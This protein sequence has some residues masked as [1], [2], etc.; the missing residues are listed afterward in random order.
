MLNFKKWLISELKTG[1][2][3]DINNWL[4]D[5]E[6][7]LPFKH[8]FGDSTR[9]IVSLSSD[10][11]ADSIL[12]K[13]KE[14]KIDY[15]KGIIVNSNGR[16]IRLGKYILSKSSPFTLKEKNWWVHKGTAIESLKKASENYEHSIIISRNPIDVI[17][18]SDHNWHSCHSPGD[19]Y[20]NCAIA[21]AKGGGLIAYVVK[22]E[23]LKNININSPEIFEDKDR[24]VYGI[25]PLCRTRLRKFVHKTEKYELAVPEDEN[26]GEDIPGFEESLRDWA[27]N[28]QDLKDKRPRLKDF[29]LMGGSYQDSNASTLFNKLFGDNLDYGQ[30]E[31]GGKDEYSGMLN[32]YEQEVEEI[33]GKFKGTFEFCHYYVSVE[34]DDG[35]NAY[36]LMGSGIMF[37][38][39]EKLLNGEYPAWD[40]PKHREYD[41]IIINWAKK[42]NIYNYINIEINDDAEGLGIRLDFESEGSTPDEFRDMLDGLKDIEEKKEELNASFHQLMMKIGLEKQNQFYHSNHKWTDT[43]FSHF[44]WDSEDDHTITVNLKEMIPLGPEKWFNP[45]YSTVHVPEYQNKK[46]SFL[47]E[48]LKILTNW[49]KNIIS[50]QKSQ[51]TLFKG[52]QQ[53]STGFSGDFNILPEINFKYENDYLY[54][55]MQLNLRA[56]HIDEHFEDAVNFL[57]FLDKYYDNFIKNVQNLAS[58]KLV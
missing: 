28:A 39:P 38:I 17:R 52:I 12:E 32:Q 19:S 10:K 55:N 18:M 16:E 40:D 26:Y 13:L 5:N 22:K 35:G 20:F 34:E 4:E 49:S 7:E 56:N 31:Y 37:K 58:K 43:Q 53:F 27:I 3:K 9:I 45:G 29:K 11:I 21:D 54:L 14:Y 48:L 44:N 33:E 47:E 2:A 15:K 30:A 6:D 51:K 42:N 8:L 24:K 46:Q 41:K 23:D 25:E 57:K 50:N 36:V 1:L